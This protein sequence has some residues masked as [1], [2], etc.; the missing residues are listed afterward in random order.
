MIEFRRADAMDPDDNV[1]GVIV[2]AIPH[3]F[4]R[5]EV[6]EHVICKVVQEPGTHQDDV[7]AVVKQMIHAY[8][9]MQQ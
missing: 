7:I 1:V 9:V 2:A 6:R 4:Q 5:N 8:Y 3:G